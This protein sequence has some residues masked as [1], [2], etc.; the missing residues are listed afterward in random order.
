[1]LNKWRGFKLLGFARAPLISPVRFSTRRH[2][3]LR[4]RRPPLC[5]P[6]AIDRPEP[7]KLIPV[8]EFPAEARPDRSPMDSSRRG[9]GGR[10]SSLPVNEFPTSDLTGSLRAAVRKLPFTGRVPMTVARRVSE[11]EHGRTGR[12]AAV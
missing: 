2:A 10:L 11:R 9:N 8:N 1:V 5:D 3:P 4:P 7:E 12:L 6:F